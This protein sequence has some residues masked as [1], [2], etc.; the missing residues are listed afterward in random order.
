MPNHSSKPSL[1]RTILA[2]AIALA[3]ATGVVAPAGASTVS[4]GTSNTIM[5]AA[6][7]VRLDVARHQVVVS[8]PATGPLAAGRRLDAVKVITPR[9]SYMLN[10]ILVSSL[11]GGDHRPEAL[12]LNFTKVEFMDYTDDSC[13][14]A[15]SVCLIEDEG[16]YPPVTP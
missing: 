14:G 5:V 11:A 9:S 8:A 1:R 4:D 6:A 13:M 7:A 16:L 3:G 12:S 10:D 2:A 15:A